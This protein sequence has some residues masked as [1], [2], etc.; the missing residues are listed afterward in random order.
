MRASSSVFHKG[1]RPYMAQA[2]PSQAPPPPRRRWRWPLIFATAIVTSYAAFRVYTHND[3]PPEVAAKL[4]KGLRAELDGGGSGQKDYNSALKFYL[5]G[6]EE[7]DKVGMDPLSDEYTGLQIKVCEMYEKLGLIE[8]ALLMYREIGTAFVKALADGSIPKAM[9]PHVIQRD[10]RVA[11]KTAMHEAGTNPNAARMG[12]LVHCIIAQRFVASK[13]Q[14]LAKLID[15]TSKLQENF[16]LNIDIGKN[17]KDMI[18]AWQ[19]FRDELFNAR[20]MFAALCLAT[21]DIGAA[22]QTKVTTTHWM[23]KAGFD[24]G[25]ILMSF[26][27]VGSMFYIQAEELEV[28]EQAKKKENDPEQAQ[29][30]VKLANDSLTSASSCFNSILSTVEKLPSQLRREHEV[31]EAQALCT[32]G[33]GVISLHKGEH[34]KASDL[35]RESRLRAKGCDF[36]DLVRSAE[37]ELEKLDKIQAEIAQ[38]HADIKYDSPNMDV[39]LTAKEHDKSTDKEKA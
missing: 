32:Y 2:Y 20:D 10:L 22:L 21:G 28:R 5:E 16:S 1:A 31:V 34:S 35:L 12:L 24:I 14:G 33:L 36:Q 19:P 17:D 29:L 30:S 8:E 18:E 27:N 11:L 15:D 13:N 7:A 37:L 9:M 26:Y 38:G 3:Y 25:A 6:L 23:T 39:V 4:R